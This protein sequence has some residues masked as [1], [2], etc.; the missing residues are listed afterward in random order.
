VDITIEGEPGH[1][2]KISVHPLSAQTP[3]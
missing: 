3:P 2:G 1:P